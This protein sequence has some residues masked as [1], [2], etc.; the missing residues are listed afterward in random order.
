M[1][2][3]KTRFKLESNYTIFVKNGLWMKEIWSAEVALI[4]NVEFQHA[5]TLGIKEHVQPNRRDSFIFQTYLT[6]N[7]SK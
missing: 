5:A 6:K 7:I 2:T 1:F 3:T 4:Q